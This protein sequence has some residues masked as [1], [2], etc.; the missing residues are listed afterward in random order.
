MRTFLLLSFEFIHFWRSFFPLDNYSA[1][2]SANSVYIPMCSSSIV[3]DNH[4]F[5]PISF[6]QTIIK[7]ND[8]VL[9]FCLWNNLRRLV[10]NIYVYS[11]C[12]CPK[13]KENYLLLCLIHFLLNL[14][15]NTWQFCCPPAFYHKSLL[16]SFLNTFVITLIFS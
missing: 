2:T 11:K 9:L 10:W 14:Y 12:H 8:F 1:I 6:P 3:S 13:R 16:D 7:F 4:Y 5:L 15:T